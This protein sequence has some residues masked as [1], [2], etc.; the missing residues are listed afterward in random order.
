MTQTNATF[1][2]RFFQTFKPFPNPEFAVMMPRLR[3]IAQDTDA[4][5]QA[6]NTALT[7]R[8]LETTHNKLSLLLSQLPKLTLSSQAIKR[9]P[10]VVQHWQRII[11]YELAEQKKPSKGELSSPF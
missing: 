9:W 11:E 6:S 3:S 2:D 5:L 1:S 4:A 8:G 10:P 7:E